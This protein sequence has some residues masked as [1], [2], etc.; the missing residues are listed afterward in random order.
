L[1]KIRYIN[2]PM[3]FTERRSFRKVSTV[4]K[5]GDK[6][7]RQ[8]GNGHEAAWPRTAEWFWKCLKLAREALNGGRLE[9]GREPVEDDD[10]LSLHAIP[11][12]WTAAAISDGLLLQEEDG[13]LSIPNWSDFFYDP[14]FAK[15]EPERSLYDFPEWL[16][17]LEAWHT[18]FG[19]AAVPCAELADLAAASGIRLLQRIEDKNKRIHRLGLILANGDASRGSYTVR[20]AGKTHKVN[21]YMVYKQAESSLGGVVGGCGGVPGVVGCVGVLSPNLNQPKPN[22]PKLT[23][24]PP[25]P[26]GAPLVDGVD[27]AF[28]FEGQLHRCRARM[29]SFAEQISPENERKLRT[30]VE[31]GSRPLRSLIEAYNELDPVVAEDQPR[32]PSQRKIKDPHALLL[33]KANEYHDIR[34]RKIAEG[35][36]GAYD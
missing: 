33:K 8:Q 6:A 35:K 2:L 13:C 16:T 11:T 31:R 28:L 14:D 32:P 22:Q 17:F 19:E 1:S 10:L 18:E 34:L 21:S 7:C 29:Q 9:T 24:Q 20:L 4:C 27:E 36:L 23:P 12:E 26:T 3:D 5:C 30:F 25:T 15:K